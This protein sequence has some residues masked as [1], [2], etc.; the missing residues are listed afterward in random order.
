MVRAS[1]GFQDWPVGRAW[2]LD[3]WPRAGNGCL[4]RAT[5]ALLCMHRLDTD[6]HIIS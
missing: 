2:P 5:A 6:F 1:D 4:E 3:A